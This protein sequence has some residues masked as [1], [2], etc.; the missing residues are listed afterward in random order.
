MWTVTLGRW[1]PIDE[2]PAVSELKKK[3]SSFH[4][5]ACVKP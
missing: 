5:E 1:W 3:L 4:G 2:H